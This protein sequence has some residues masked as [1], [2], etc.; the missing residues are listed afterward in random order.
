[1][2]GFLSPAESRR[3]LAKAVMAHAETHYGDEGAAWDVIVECWTLDEITQELGRTR[4]LK[5]ALKKFTEIAA[6]YGERRR[7]I[8]AEAW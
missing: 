1:M 4:T 5:G 2:A 8:Q 6:L 7:E 3:M